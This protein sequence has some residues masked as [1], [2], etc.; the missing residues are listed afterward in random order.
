MENDCV[1]S[2]HS[3]SEC[4]EVPIKDIGHVCPDF[5]SFIPAIDRLT[6]TY[7]KQRLVNYYFEADI[8]MLVIL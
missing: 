1:K 7:L 4:F 8:Y 6:P 2:C 5:L 3:L